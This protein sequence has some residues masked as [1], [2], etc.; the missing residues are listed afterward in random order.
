MGYSD[1]IAD[2][3]FWHLSATEFSTSKKKCVQMET[4]AKK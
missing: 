2:G 1:R 3:R 4:F